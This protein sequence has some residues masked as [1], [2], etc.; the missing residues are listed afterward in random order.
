MVDFHHCIPHNE[1]RVKESN[2][3]VDFVDLKTLKFQNSLPGKLKGE[4]LGVMMK[5]I[6]KM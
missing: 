1:V 3:I 4:H 2:W 6:Q 5:H